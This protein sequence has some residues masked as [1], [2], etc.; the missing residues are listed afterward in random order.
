MSSYSLGMVKFGSVNH[1]C[2]SERYLQVSHLRGSLLF[3]GGSVGAVP[4]VFSN[5]GPAGGAGGAGVTAILAQVAM[6]R[7]ASG[8]DPQTEVRESFRRRRKPGKTRA[9]A[10]M[11]LYLSTRDSAGRSLKPSIF[12]S[13]CLHCSGLIPGYG[14]ADSRKHKVTP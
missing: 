3:V 7:P 13:F 9:V 6:R 1:K 4:Q 11:A 12:L 10:L 2:R 8:E 14:S 5:Q